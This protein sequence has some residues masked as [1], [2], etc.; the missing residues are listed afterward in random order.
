MIKEFKIIAWLM[1]GTLFFACTKDFEELNTNPNQP[2]SVEPEFL[3]TFAQKRLMDE[4]W[5]QWAGG[6]MSLMLSQ[7]WAQN[8]YTD[9]SRYR[10]RLNVTDN[11]WTFLFASG[12][13]NLNEVIKINEA[14]L[15]SGVAGQRAAQANNQ[16]AVARILKAWTFHTATDIWGDIP[17]SEATKGTESSSPKLDRQEDV[18]AGILSELTA[19]VEQIDPSAPGF[20]TGD[21]IYSGNMGAWQK[22][23]NSLK[24]RVALRMS[25]VKSAEAS[26][27]IQ[28][29]VNSGIHFT[30]NADNAH[31]RYL[32][33]APNQNR[34]YDDR[35]NAARRDFAVSN[36]LIDAM[37]DRND[38]RI[39]EFADPAVT[40]GDYVG[41]VYGLADAQA[42]ATPT[43]DVSQPAGAGNASKI[44]APDAPAVIME[45]SEVL[46]ILAEAAQ[47]GFIAGDAEDYYNQAITASMNRWG[48]MDGTAIADYIAQSN[49]AYD[50]AEWN[51][52]I[53]VQK[54]LS[55]YMQGFE[56]WAEWRRLDFGILQMPDAGPLLGTGIPV[57]GP[58]PI[59]EQQLNSANV[60]A[61]VSAQGLSSA[62]D[63]N[64]RMWWDVN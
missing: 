63:L 46:F 48:I 12:L 47:R 62:E 30:S 5:N 11:L 61:A 1:I 40:S 55:L 54:W 49:V 6:R 3:M 32:T 2:T 20:A 24:L 27:A 34:Y 53:G 4:T 57:R 36:T 10:F 22:L 37:L 14:T 16:I 60:S 59:R 44:L 15:E 7:Y 18:Y 38:P 43:E 52:S 17:Y 41:M 64:T 58:Y 56:G 51:T 19:A 23:G 13:N 9:E 25:D 45:Y 39:G 8:E 50:A 42:L 28:S 26:A 29:V 31:F 33:G 21:V 35:F